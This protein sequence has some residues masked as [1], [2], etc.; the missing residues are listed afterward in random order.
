MGVITSTSPLGPWEDPLGKPLLSTDTKGLTDCKNPFDPGV[1]VDDDGVGYLTFGGSD[2]AQKFDD[3]ISKASKI[4]RLGADMVSID[5]EIATIPAPYFFEA[6]ELNFINGT[7][8][9][10]YCSDWNC[11]SEVWDYNCDIPGKCSMIYLTSKTPLITESWQMGGEV[12]KNPGDFGYE[13]SNNHTH[14]HKF[15]GKWYILYHTLFLKAD[16]KIKGGYRSICVDE[17]N[18]NE[19]NVI[20][21]DGIITRKGVSL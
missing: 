4:V 9:Y 8:V 12:L 5:S 2:E 1:V 19:E 17:I 18:V 13:H 14:M 11:H 10:T 6:S 7:Y 21:K 15:K 20:I 16:K 3:R